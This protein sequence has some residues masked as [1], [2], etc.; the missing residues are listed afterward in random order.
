M[1][2]DEKMIAMGCDHAGY[3]LKEK[4]T[5]HFE[6][7]GYVFSDYGCFSEESVDYP[8][9]VHPLAHDISTGSLPSGII[10][11]GTGN[12]VA[13][14]ANKYLN[15]R[16]AV[17]WTAEVAKFAR[18]HNDAN[19][20]AL[21]ARMIGEEIALD[22]VLTFLTTEFEGDRHQRRIDKIRGIIS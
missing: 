7:F 1:G 14:T 18:L 22:I 10:I 11:C 17:C 19:I 20:L 15:I 5:K 4:I 2:K 21:P 8:D 13:M 9:I 3:K 12:G 16:A 6:S